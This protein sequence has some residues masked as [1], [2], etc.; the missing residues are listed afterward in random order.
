MV[1]PKAERARRQESASDLSLATATPIATDQ[2]TYNV[3]VSDIRHPRL[4]WVEKPGTSQ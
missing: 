2:D 1:E 4:F 3:A